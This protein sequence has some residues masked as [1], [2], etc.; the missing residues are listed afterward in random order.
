M[1]TF[2]IPVFVISIALLLN[3][4][5]FD[6]VVV[7]ECA[8][9]HPNSLQGQLLCQKR[10]DKTNK[11][12]AREK[13]AQQ[14][15]DADEKRMREVVSMIRTEAIA[16]SG[17]SLSALKDALSNKL[18]KEDFSLQKSQS[19]NKKMVIVATVKTSCSSSYSILINVRAKDESNNVDSFSAWEKSPLF[20]NEK[21]E[22]L[23][24]EF[25]WSQK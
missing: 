25:Q 9:T 8:L 2:F 19:N 18:P 22:R 4:C 15:V 5:S 20:D 12:I 6:E 7:S 13:A 11:V 24:Y 16:Y 21:K 23:L 14:C 1:S 10:V 3:H 17:K